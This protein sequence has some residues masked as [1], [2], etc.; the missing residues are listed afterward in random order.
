[1]PF[2]MLA[3]FWRDG[4]NGVKI[5]RRSPPKIARTVA[6]PVDDR[7]PFHYFSLLKSPFSILRQATM[8]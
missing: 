6:E 3:F 2:S 5:R 7:R 8:V 1:M 4:E